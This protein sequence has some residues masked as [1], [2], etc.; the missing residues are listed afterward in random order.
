MLMT[1]PPSI[2]P[3]TLVGLTALP[4]SWAATIR[5]IFPSSSRMHTCVA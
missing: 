1:T 5:S 4:T 2:C 3:S